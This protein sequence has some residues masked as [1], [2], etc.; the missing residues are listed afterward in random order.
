[1]KSI[2]LMG[3][4]VALVDD[5]DY[6]NL[7]RY[8]WEYIAPKN[9]CGNEYAR[10]RATINGKRIG[11]LMHR[12]IMSSTKGQIIDHKD[13]NGLNNQRENLRVCSMA[14]NAWN[15]KVQKSNLLGFRGVHKRYSTVKIKNRKGEE[16]TYQRKPRYIAFI[17]HN[18]NNI[19]IGSFLTPEVA[20]EAYNQAALKYYGEFAY[21][22]QIKE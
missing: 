12:M 1:M 10:T 9:S 5:C 8:K 3:N 4:K 21:L 20:A 2:Q 17:R 14:E 7:M 18:G 6:E 13:R 19:Y 16:V 22:N 11:T 15:R